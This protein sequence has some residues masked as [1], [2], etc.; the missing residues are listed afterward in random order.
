MESS[1]E[2]PKSVAYA[3]ATQQAH[4]VGKSPKKFRTRLGVAMAKAKFDKPKK[5]YKKTAQIEV[6]PEVAGVLGGLGGGLTMG[7]GIA[8][9]TAAGLAPRGRVT[10]S[11]DI[12]RKAALVGAPAGGIAALAL[13]KKYK[14]G[15]RAAAYLARKAPRG[16][17]GSPDTDR[18]ILEGALPLALGIGGGALG[19]LV[20]GGA[21]GGIQRARGSLYKKDREKTAET[22]PEKRVEKMI[23]QLPKEFRPLFKGQGEPVEKKAMHPALEGGLYSLGG[24]AA[25]MGIGALAG[26]PMAGAA[27]GTGAGTGLWAARKIFKGKD[28]RKKEKTAQVPA[29]PFEFTLKGMLIKEALSKKKLQQAQRRKEAIKATPKVRYESPE[30]AGKKLLEAAGVKDPGDAGARSA[31]EKARAKGIE[32]PY[33]ARQRAAGVPPPPKKKPGPKVETKPPS[34][35]GVRKLEPRKLKPRKL[36]PKTLD[37][38]TPSSQTV[39]KVTKQV[40]KLRRYGVPI[41]AG[42]AGAAALGG[43][44]YLAT[45][46]KKQHQE[47]ID[48]FWKGK[49]KTAMLDGLMD[50][51]EKISQGG[52]SL[53]NRLRLGA[54]SP[55]AQASIQGAAQG[56]VEPAA[57]AGGG[58]ETPPPAPPPPTTPPSP[59]GGDIGAPSAD[60]FGGAGA[61]GGGDPMGGAGGGSPLGPSAGGSPLGGANAPPPPP[62]PTGGG[63]IG[64]G[65]LLSPKRQG[66]RGLTTEG[67][68]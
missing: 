36:K 61:P 1:P 66:A 51:L 17:L 56:N 7:R 21:V 39:K 62:P 3:T 64:A 48:K 33:T 22:K 30:E 11:E 15:P 18:A 4:K 2:T 12:A 20:T 35:A 31:R 65:S 45:R 41:G 60:P 55:A 67:P 40:S 13:A 29:H 38:P 16:L 23:E 53:A 26:N 28:K 52:G 37:V 54:S 5:E 14:L 32:Q 57:S 25:G 49:R 68:P 47:D 63:G 9:H 59:G 43:V 27:L 8:G 46:K 42:L 44:A 24:G 50:E 58:A 6:N 19:G 10:R 34:R